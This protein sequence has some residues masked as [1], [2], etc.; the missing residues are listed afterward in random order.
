MEISQI[1]EP[2]QV[3]IHGWIDKKIMGYTHNGIL[4]N[5]KEQ[6]YVICKK[7]EGPGRNYL[8]EI[9]QVQKE[10]GHVFSSMLEL[11]SIWD[12]RGT[13]DNGGDHQWSQRKGQGRKKAEIVQ[14]ERL[15]RVSGLN[16]QG[17]HREGGEG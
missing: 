11:G 10:K 8:S 14:T 7:M 12:T 13:S 9:T 4:L 16:T 17:P 2:I 6:N 1:I 15:Q 5:N 3:S